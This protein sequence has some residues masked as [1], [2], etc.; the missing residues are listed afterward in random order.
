MSSNFLDSLPAELEDQDFRVRVIDEGYRQAVNNLRDK[1]GVFL[2]VSVSY[3]FAEMLVRFFPTQK[4][5]DPLGDDI[6]FTASIGELLD[7][8]GQPTG[9]IVDVYYLR[10]ELDE[11]RIGKTI[12]SLRMRNLNFS[13]LTG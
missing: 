6:V 13:A 5:D 12:G 7:E 1:P 2:D 11:D 10:I 8:D 9:R 4:I 3:D